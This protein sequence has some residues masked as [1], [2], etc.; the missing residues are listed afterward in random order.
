LLNE[1]QSTTFWAAVNVNRLEHVRVSLR[2]LIKYLDKEKQ[3]NVITTFEDDLD[4]DRIS[5]HDL[6]PTYTNLQSY[7]DRVEAYI[8]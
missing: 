2:D 4:I 8:R 3:V 1:L 5:D 6:V 7:K